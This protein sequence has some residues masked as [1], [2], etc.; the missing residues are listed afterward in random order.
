[1]AMLVILIPARERAGVAAADNDAAPARAGGE[2]RFVLSHD[3]LSIAAQ[4]RC[5]PALLPKADSVFA[6]LPESDLSWQRIPLPKAPAARLRA[7]IVGV[8][9]EELL[10]EPE[11]LH[12][13]LSPGA[14]A[15]QPAWVAVMNKDWVAQHLGL[16]ER[17]G[18]PV[19]RLLPG[20]WPDDLPQGHFWEAT[21]AAAGA[22][23]GVTWSDAH[24]VASIRLQGGLAHALMPFWIVQPARWSTSATVAAPAE[25]W[26]GAPVLVLSE[27]QRALQAARSLWNLRQFDLAP[28]HRG[29]RALRDSA[30]RFFSP[31][32]RPVR[33]GL[34]GLLLVQVLGLNLWAL[35]Q[36]STLDERRREMVSLLQATHPQVRAVLDA[37]LQ[38]QRETDTLRAA[39]GRAG[40]DDLEALLN[41]AAAAWPDGM[42]PVASL[43]FEPGRLSF[44]AAG[45]N[46]PQI[47]QFSSQLRPAGWRIESANGALSL[48]RAAPGAAS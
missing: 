25:R 1:M 33:W 5:A 32:W 45:W 13:A 3:G 39:A 44:S 6:V 23:M 14:S 20:A 17:G 26:L 46:A 31:A 34:L 30:R 4:G 16:L 7:A 11:R 28:R 21:G 22:P 9:E 40:D 24:G 2:Y 35:H 38:M 8:L 36:R 10:D 41:A 43:R 47:E 18:A 27:E 37:P 19:E 12:F 42:P 29:A 48:S 15:G